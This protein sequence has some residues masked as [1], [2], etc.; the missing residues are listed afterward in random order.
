[1]PGA[2][3]MFKL[4]FTSG[5]MSCELRSGFWLHNA[6]LSFRAKAAWSVS[7]VCLFLGNFLRTHRCF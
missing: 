3:R 1:M 2:V 6:S 4:R 5:L 7:R